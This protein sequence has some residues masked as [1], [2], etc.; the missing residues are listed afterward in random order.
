MVQTALSPSWYSLP[1]HGSLRVF[2]D[3]RFFWSATFAKVFPSRH[4]Y[5]V[6]FQH[7]CLSF[8]NSVV[9]PLIEFMHLLRGVRRKQLIN[10]YVGWGDKN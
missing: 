5:R 3:A 1:S 7:I 6:K 4:C 10:G 2:I 8:D 9:K